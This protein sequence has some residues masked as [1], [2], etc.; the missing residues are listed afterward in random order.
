MKNGQSG[1]LAFVTGGSRGIGRAIALA[2]ADEGCDTLINYQS[3][4]EAAE[5]VVCELK[6]K[7]VRAKAYKADISNDTETQEMVKAIIEEFGSVDILVNNA[8]INRDRGFLKMTRQMWDEVLGVNLNGPFNI[9]HELLPGM[10]AK[11]WGR[12]INIASMNGQ[13]GNFGQANYTVTKGGLM[14]LTF[15]LAREFARKGI[16]VNAVSPGYTETDMT[17]AMP[18]AAVDIVKSMIPL[19]RMGTPEEVAAAVVFVASPQASYITG[20]VIGVNGGMY[21]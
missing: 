7:N 4:D 12:I 16:T 14:S 9:T 2:L 20:Q 6:K 18:A 21:M 19:G 15:T 1:R 8:A 5:E 17:K 11:G 13:T 10:V 3:A